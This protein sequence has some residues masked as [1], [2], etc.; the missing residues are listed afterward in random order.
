MAP[1]DVA[2]KAVQL[3]KDVFTNLGP[4]LLQNQLEIHED[5]FSS[6][7]LRLHA[8]YD[9]VRFLDMDECEVNLLKETERM[10]RILNVLKEYIAE[11]DEAYREERTILPLS[12]LV[13]YF[14][15]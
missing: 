6:C 14:A 13:R 1:D 10:V 15:E 3:L 11:C 5:F 8:L 4:R 12:R 2:P 9:T 7:F